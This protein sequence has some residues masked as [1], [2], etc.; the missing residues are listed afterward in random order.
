[1][2]ASYVI[3]IRTY[4]FK[5]DASINIRQTLYTS[6]LRH[7]V[8]G[9]KWVA[10]PKNIT[11]SESKVH[12][13]FLTI[14]LSVIGRFLGRPYRSRPI[15]KQFCRL[16]AR[17]L[18]VLCRDA[19]ALCKKGWTHRDEFW[20]E[21]CSWRKQHLIKSWWWS[22]KGLGYSAPKWPPKWS[23]SRFFITVAER[24]IRLRRFSAD[25]WSRQG[26]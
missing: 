14:T 13:G 26:T 10:M 16:S 20:H 8:S 3:W 5:V 2:A 4:R 7:T 6:R 21:C 18:S 19:R 12:P 1:M 15:P 11:V 9:Q 24:V 17:R 25:C 22:V 23:N